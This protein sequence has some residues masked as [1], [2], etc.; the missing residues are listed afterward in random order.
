MYRE[1]IQLAGKLNKSIIFAGTESQPL[2]E[3]LRTPHIAFTTAEYFAVE[4]EM[5]VLLVTSTFN[6]HF[7][8]CI[9][10]ST[11][12]ISF[13]FI[14]IFIKCIPIFLQVATGRDQ[15][16]PKRAPIW[17]YSELAKIFERAGNY[18]S[19]KRIKIKK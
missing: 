10:V 18:K 15:L 17:Y 2:L 9:T 11:L 14:F 19:N 8:A 4:R 3:S 6:R 16:L 5:N 1:K 12:F 13:L 7:D